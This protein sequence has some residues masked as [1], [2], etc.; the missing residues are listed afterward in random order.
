L[1]AGRAPAAGLEPATRRLT[2]E[3]GGPKD[4]GTLE[5]QPLRE[6]RSPE[7]E[8][9]TGLTAH[10]Q[11]HSIAE[12]TDDAGG[13]K[14]QLEKPSESEA[15]GGSRRDPEAVLKGAIACLT[16]TLLTAPDDAIL[17]LV[18]ERAALRAELQELTDGMMRSDD[19]RTR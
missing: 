10:S 12:P 4:H 19:K 16:R 8:R 7:I 5:K 13:G 2:A 3:V 14:S 1:G 9:A 6:T 17:G 15:N 11:A 18:A